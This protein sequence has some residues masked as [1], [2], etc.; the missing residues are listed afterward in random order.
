MSAD[1]H[2]E[3]DHHLKDFARV[4]LND[5]EFDTGA[6]LDSRNVKRLTR[7][8]K[9]Q[10]CRREDPPNAIPVVVGTEFLA[11][12]GLHPWTLRSYVSTQLPLLS[13]KVICLHGKHRICAAREF[14][15]ASDQWWTVKIFDSGRESLYCSGSIH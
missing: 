14:L 15:H 12:Q 10:G 11:Q 5:I 2:A 6:D 7:V 9:L 8:F 4:K 1:V 13:G 3:I